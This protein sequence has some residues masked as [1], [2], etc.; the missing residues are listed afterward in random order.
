[1]NITHI[2]RSIHILFTTFKSVKG[3][4]LCLCVYVAIIIIMFT[5]KNYLVK[6]F[7][8]FGSQANLSLDTSE[9][10]QSNLIPRATLLTRAYFTL[11][12]SCTALMSANSQVS[13]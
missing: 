3:L 11:H 12:W 1:M 8:S 2:C 5:L 10:I 13:L 7:H 9:N 6:Q 4:K